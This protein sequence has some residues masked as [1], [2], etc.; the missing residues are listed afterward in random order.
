MQI[1]RA[2]KIV[3]SGS[4]RTAPPSQGKTAR[5]R[6]SDYG[7]NHVIDRPAN[8]EV[9]KLVCM[10]AAFARFATI[11]GA[12]IAVVALVDHAG[13]DAFAVFW[14]ASVVGAAVVVIAIKQQFAFAH[15]AVTEIGRGAD[16]VVVTRR[17]RGFGLVN[18]TVLAATAVHSARFAVVAPALAVARAADDGGMAAFAA[19]LI[20]TVDGATQAVVTVFELSHYACAILATVARSASVAVAAA[21]VVVGVDTD[22]E[23]IALVKSA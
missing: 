1:L 13:V 8:L 12:R 4:D 23:R 18:T 20:A 9:E 17:A 2:P 14:V 16:R 10:D 11:G 19:Q 7:P 15:A 5:S 21:Q 6:Q 3:Q 22:V